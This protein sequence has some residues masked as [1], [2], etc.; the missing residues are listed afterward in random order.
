MFLIRCNS[1][2]KSWRNKKDLQR[3]TKIKPFIN[4]YKWDRITFPPEKRGLKNNVK[5]A[6]NVMYAKQEEYILLTF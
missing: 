2:F 6:L 4:K 3:I 5:I 1:H